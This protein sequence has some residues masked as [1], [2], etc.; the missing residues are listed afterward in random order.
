MTEEGGSKSGPMATLAGPEDLAERHGKSDT[1]KRTRGYVTPWRPKQSV[2]ACRLP[3]DAAT[4]RGLVLAARG[5]HFPWRHRQGAQLR[6]CMGSV[7]SRSWGSLGLRGK[8][9]S[10]FRNGT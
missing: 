1:Q 5:F 8:Q 4:D 10:S 7:Y 9:K 2:Q 6:T 3:K